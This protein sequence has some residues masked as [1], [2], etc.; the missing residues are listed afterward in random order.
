M[1]T[2]GT[3]TFMLTDVV[4]STSLWD[5]LPAA[6]SQALVRHD[7][8]MTQ[9]VEGA[10]GRLIKSMGEGDS[11]VSVFARAGD[12]LRAGLAAHAALAAEAWP[13]G[14]A[15]H[16]R[17]A[18]HT[19]DA[20]L[21]DGQYFGPTLNRAARLR[22]LAEGGEVLLSHV[23]AELVAA[24]LPPGVALVELGRQSLRGLGEPDLVVAVTGPHVT[25]PRLA[26]CPYRGLAS[27][28]EDDSG[29]FFGRQATVDRALDRLRA[30]PFLVVVGASG[31]G[32]S[33]LA[34][35]GIVPAVL[36]GALPGRWKAAASAPGDDPIGALHRA[37]G[38]VAADDGRLLLVVD[39]F[40]EIF[41]RCAEPQIRETFVDLVLTSAD[42]V[43]L[44]LRADFYG[45][46]ASV[47]NLAALVADHQVLLGPMSADELGEAIEKP[48]RK[49]GLQLE[50]GLA[51]LLV[52][53]VLGEPGSLPLLSHALVETWER[54]EG[55]KL[56]LAGYQAAGGARGA[57]ARTADTTFARLPLGRQR[58][59]RRVLLRLVEPGEGTEDT[60][61][62]ATISEL[63]ADAD[64]DDVT[65]VLEELAGAR[66]I[67]VQAEG[68]EIAHEALIREWPR[69]RGWIDDDRE[70]LRSLRSL[71][72]AAD[73]WTAAGR[74]PGELYRGGRLAAADRLDEDELTPIEREFLVASREAAER[75]QEELRARVIEQARVNRRLRA[76]LVGAISLLAMAVAGG[77]VAFLQRQ[78][79][80]RE[81]RAARAANRV[82]SEQL[83]RGLAASA[84]DLR[85]SN[86]FLS[87]VLATESIARFEPA[88]AEARAALVESRMALAGR[89][90]VP[91]GDPIPV[92]DALTTAVRP[93]GDLAATGNRDGTADLWD[94]ATRERL[95]QL[96]G[97]SAGIQS[98]AFTA[99][100]RWIVA[101]AADHRVWRWPI[102]QRPDGAMLAGTGLADLGAIVWSVAPAPTGTMIAA[103]TEAGEAWLL[104][105]ATGGRLGRA[106]HT[107][108]GSLDSVAFSPDGKTLLA[109][110]RAG[111]LLGWSISSRRLRF[112]RP[113][114]GPT[115][116]LQLDVRDEPAP[117]AFVSALADGTVRVW[118]LRTGARLRRGPFDGPAGGVPVG[119]RGVT[120]GAGG[121]I[122]ELGGPDG[123]VYSWSLSKRRLVGKTGRAHRDRV[124]SAARSAD[125]LTLVTLGDDHT[126]Q[127]WT[128]RRR[129]DPVR[130]IDRLAARPSS[131]AI[132]PGGRILAVGA[133][134][135]V[136][137][138]L[139]ASTGRE[140]SALRGG[141]G[142]V[143][144]LLFDGS[145]RVVTGTSEGAL[146]VWDVASGR[147]L[148]SRA[149]AHGGAISSVAV[150]SADGRRLFASGGADRTVR[151]WS[152][153]RLASAG[154]PLGPLAAPVTDVAFSPD[155][156]TIA[157]STER[158]DI[159]R[160][161]TGG[162]SEGSFNVTNDTVW[163]I[164]Y[165]PGDT[166][167]SA[168]AD[169]VVSLWALSA[170]G[171]PR[172]TQA[173]ASHRS[174][175]LDVAFVGSSTVV[176]GSGDGRV[177]LWDTASGAAVG[178]AITVSDSPVRHVGTSPE[179]VIWAASDSGE[180]SR[181]DALSVR[182]ACAEAAASFD[183]RQ[184]ARLLAGRAL[185][186]CRVRARR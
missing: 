64:A 17:S 169:E 60:R 118:D 114:A 158:G 20:D 53:D 75:A 152:P 58:I 23:T 173:L 162:R 31:S 178:P 69:L 26:V 107:D 9:A 87:T 37:L 93:A 128:E 151:L 16:I 67:T 48:A 161:T 102:P 28:E 119:V 164:A 62:R 154:G 129:H 24:D 3:S 155:G 13:E 22:S 137:H 182:A 109:E 184:R 82:A 174:G 124:A 1:A 149:G 140:R 43:L 2:T 135:G 7:A 113:D 70:R 144:A 103:S 32:K 165:G 61:R 50:P 176:A 72:R 143:T 100:G 35:A 76:L 145:S 138:L 44:V 29:L 42:A 105:A 49:V 97:P 163:A 39:Q 57:I 52:A 136:V 66:L 55:R 36:E 120:F 110:S 126:L 84:V 11:T 146:A 167:A 89:K 132:A 18:L 12:G 77:S 78:R 21:R 186:G 4:G 156:A 40:E 73:L 168:T 15:I 172:R 147:L 181:I 83:A 38:R 45:H 121:D 122:L 166:L 85:D 80:D 95:A 177:R 91:Y 115:V 99:D 101:G 108:T 19:G 6:M 175:A 111:R 94:L 179:G 142:A 68:V 27:F 65:A 88:L 127:V 56:T 112:S 150:S 63:V 185:L 5:T 153:G 30:H 96:R 157:A 81:A 8:L 74:D 10:G 117:P 159:A 139:D 170:G 59:A 90:L 130:R 134:D 133:S 41:T 131:M 106:L 79:A 51:D 33:S 125:R 14:V 47:P 116:S 180:I 160:W 123:A 71:T 183:R 98:L 86:P 141:H 46:C 54:R 92:G 25:A 171:A 34:R 104:D 148:A